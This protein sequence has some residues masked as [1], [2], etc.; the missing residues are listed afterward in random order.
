ME[1]SLARF[2]LFSSPPLE[3]L[4]TGLVDA[5]AESKINKHET[6]GTWHIPCVARA[7]A[8]CALTTLGQIW[9]CTSALC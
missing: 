8:I 4:C 9:E 6:L 3:I 5:L 2:E 1:L 7:H